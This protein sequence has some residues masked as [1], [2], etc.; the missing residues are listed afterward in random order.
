MDTAGGF[1]VL[2]TKQEF[3]GDLRIEYDFKRVDSHDRGVNIS[4]IQARGDGQDEHL[5][6]I[7]TWSDQR[8]EAQM[9]DYFMHM[10]TYHISY[11]AFPDD[12]IRGRRYL[13]SRNEKLIG[14]NLTGEI[15]G[16]GLFDDQDWIH[17]TI[18]KRDIELSAEF[19][20][21]GKATLLCHLQ[22]EDKPPVTAGQVGLRLMPGRKSQFKNFRIGQINDS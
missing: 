14:T 2:W 4:Y 5:P 15:V 8:R 6:D 11:A 13:P 21:P 12:Y 17:I 7:T 16:S 3:A 19:K 20:H 9:R 22:N 10:P 18:I 1:G